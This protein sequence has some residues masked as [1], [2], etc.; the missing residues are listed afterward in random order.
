MKVYVLNS[1]FEC[2]FC[3]LGVYASMPQALQALN[4]QF[5]EEDERIEDFA[6]VDGQHSIIYTN[7]ATYYI[8]EHILEG[9][10]K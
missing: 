10:E 4:R 8:E 7:M 9:I 2:E 1:L 6:A 5:L 3:T